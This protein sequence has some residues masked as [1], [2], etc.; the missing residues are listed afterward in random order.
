MATRDPLTEIANVK[1]FED[2][3]SHEWSRSQRYG[4]SLGILMIDLD[5]FKEVN[6]VHGHS[7]GDRVLVSVANE[8]CTHTRDTDLVARIG[9]DEFAVICPQ[10]TIQGLQKLREQLE[11]ELP[12]AI[13]FGV[14]VSI[15]AAEMKT[16]DKQ[17]SE[18]L[19]RADAAMYARKSSRRR[20]P[21]P[22]D[23]FAKAS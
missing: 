22:D 5:R 9:G 13:G 6:D 8:L 20:A 14:G 23:L 7:A 17:S 11:A 12:S 2:R 4:G 16:R 18:M 10:T 21:S 19:E 15:G 3:L 1:A